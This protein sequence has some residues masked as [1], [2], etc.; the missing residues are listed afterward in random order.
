[1]K[2]RFAVLIAVLPAV[3]LAQEDGGTAR[4]AGQWQMSVDTPHGTVKGGLAVQQD[5][6]KIKGTYTAEQFGA[7]KLSGN[8]EGKKVSFRIELPG[9]EATFALNGKVD[10]DK[11]SGSTEMGGGW[12]AT[13][14][15]GQAAAKPVP[16]TV[17]AYHTV[18]GDKMGGST[19]MGGGWTATREGG[20][21]A[22]KPVLGTVTAFKVDTLEFGV[23]PD[24]GSPIAVKV[25]P[26]TDVVTIPPSETGLAKAKPAKLTD[27][28]LG[29]RVLVSFVD[30]MA[31]ARRIVL[32]S[33]DDIARRN[34]R[35][36]LDWQRRGIS[37]IVASAGGGVVTLEQRTPQGVKTT[38]IT[39]SGKAKVRRYA[40]DSVKFT[41]AQ[42]SA[43]GEIAAGDQVQAR[44]EKNDDG[45]LSA[46]EI[47][48]GTFLTRVGKVTAVNADS[49]EIRIEDLATKQTLTVRVAEG[50]QL[51]AL[52]DMRGMMAGMPPGMPHGAPAAAGAS[53]DIKQTLE[54]AAGGRD[55]RRESGHRDR[56]DQH[57]G[58]EQRRADRHHA[59]GQ[60]RFPDSG[61]AG[62]DRRRGRDGGHLADARRHVDGSRR[63]ADPSGDHSMRASAMRASAMRASAL[64][65]ALLACLSAAQAQPSLRGTVTDPSGAAVPGAVGAASERGGRRQDGRRYRRGGAWRRGPPSA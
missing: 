25:G 37:G 65:P 40:P 55:R 7:L 6:S 3:L 11:M 38:T 48:F 51:K 41:D 32:I 31:E 44:G 42:P 62:A 27:I 23:K 10:G 43:L 46:E 4:I 61:G 16:G 2:K 47:V 58:R 30:G 20:Q 57:A 29:D 64:L 28:A 22:A 35:E 1:M 17:T 59:P 60:R 45:S 56:G 54:S 33:A 63:R 50:S 14:E 18:D 53:F 52:P 8:V 39:V 9:G 36:R 26:E 13:R 5:G 12:T 21:A 49:R 15:G 24:S 34:E 19:E